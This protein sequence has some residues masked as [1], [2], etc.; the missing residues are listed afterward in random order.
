MSFLD[1]ITQN[2]PNLDTRHDRG[3]T[4][5]LVETGEYLGFSYL[6]GRVNTQYGDKAKWKGHDATYVAGLATKVVAVA[7]DIFGF[8][9]G[10]SHHANTASNA[11]LGAHFVAK[12]AEDGMAA[13]SGSSKPAKS[14]PAASS[15]TSTLPAA[16]TTA[17]GAIP[18]APQPGKYLD[19]DR[20]SAIASMNAG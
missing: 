20:V 1:R 10:W 15:S 11:L 7:A 14:L 17:L 18:P 6:A 13:A 3:L 5:H 2:A 16:K 19:L 8:G 9:D 12:G 4:S